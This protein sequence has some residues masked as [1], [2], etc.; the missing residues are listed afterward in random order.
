MKLWE[1]DKYVN[2]EEYVKGL[3]LLA[4]LAEN[5]CTAEIRWT[6]GCD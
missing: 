6:I 3:C 5:T 1:F 2:S 4:V